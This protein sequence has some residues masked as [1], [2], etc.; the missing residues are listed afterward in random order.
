MRNSKVAALGMVAMLLP[1][2]FECEQYLVPNPKYQPP[3]QAIQPQS[4]GFDY[5]AYIN[6]FRELLKKVNQKKPNNKEGNFYSADPFRD[7]PIK[8]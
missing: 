1:A 7:L 4:A 6:D 3:P 8:I 2:I 5:V